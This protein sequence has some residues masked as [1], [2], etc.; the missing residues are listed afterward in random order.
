MARGAAELKTLFSGAV[1]DNATLQ[2]NG[3]WEIDF[4]GNLKKRYL[5]FGIDVRDTPTPSG[6]HREQPTLSR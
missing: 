2:L 1:R 4:F 6:R 3:S 5:E